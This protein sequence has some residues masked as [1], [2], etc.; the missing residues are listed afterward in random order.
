MYCRIVKLKKPNRSFLLILKSRF[1]NNRF[2]YVSGIVEKLFNDSKKS[3]SSYG[4]DIIIES[5]F[6]RH[7]FLTNQKIDFTYLD[8]GAWRPIKS[9]NTYK[10]YTNG[11]FGTVVEPNPNMRKLW[12]SIR[13]K[14]Q[15]IESACSTKPIVK[16]FKLT[17]FAASNTTSLSFANS[18]IKTQNLSKPKI[19]H[20]K[21][22]KLDTLIQMHVK[23][24][25]GNFV[26]DIDIEGQDEAVIL[27]HEF[28]VSYRPILILIEDHYSKSI[29]NSKI[30]KYLMERGYIFV[31]R[32]V[33]T[34]FFIDSRSELKKSQLR[35]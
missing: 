33:L 10:F 8:V 17:E 30:S 7:F 3:Y 14:D 32:T 9:S 22:M 20:V 13:P 4:E 31:G 35:I 24:F 1:V 34:S 2:L 11:I 15:Y 21:G 18:I 27:R 28:N 26:L 5:I 29:R 19:L 23:R 25:P 16:F 12:R 6:K